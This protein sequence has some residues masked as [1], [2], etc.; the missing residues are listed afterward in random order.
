LRSLNLVAQDDAEVASREEEFMLGDHFLVAPV[1]EE[2]AKSIKVF[3]PEG[4]WY[5]YWTNHKF[6]GKQEIEVATPMDQIPLFVRAGA[7]IPKQPKM[8]YTDEFSFDQLTLDIYYGEGEDSSEIYEDAGDGYEYQKGGFA[9]RKITS[10]NTQYVYMLRQQVEGEFDSCYKTYRASFH[11]F[12]QPTMVMVDGE[13]Y[14]DKIEKQEDGFI[15]EMP[16]N[17]KETLIS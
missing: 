12:P 8:Q 3:L 17:F 9:K 15:L 1:S 7:V 5:N 4:Q 2:G 10:L 14:T 6:D 13:N 16:K 11:G